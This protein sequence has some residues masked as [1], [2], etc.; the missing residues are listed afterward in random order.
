MLLQRSGHG[1]LVG[2]DSWPHTSAPSFVPGVEPA[3]DLGLSISHLGTPC[4]WWIMMVTLVFRADS[5]WQRLLYLSKTQRPVEQSC[6]NA[7]RCQIWAGH[8]SFTCLFKGARATVQGSLC[9]K[10]PYKRLH[11]SLLC[12]SEGERPHSHPPCKGLPPSMPQPECL[13]IPKASQS[14]HQ[15]AARAWKTSPVTFYG[16]QTHHL[17]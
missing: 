2:T 15:E 1:V 17:H 11:R 9:T 12:W 7:F 13:P 4:G 5:T 10:T 16:G 14:E 8:H 6:V 3:A